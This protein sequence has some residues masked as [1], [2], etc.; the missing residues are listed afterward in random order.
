MR[1]C[2]CVVGGSRAADGPRLPYYYY[3]CV[4][5]GRDALCAE[6][7]WSSELDLA[8]SAREMGRV[9]VCVCVCMMYAPIP[10]NAS[11]PNIYNI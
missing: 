11:V 7:G 10:T 5:V 3:C 1:I 8:W 4:A 2:G 6:H 9:Y